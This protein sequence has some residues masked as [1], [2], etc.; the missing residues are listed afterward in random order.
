MKIEFSFLNHNNFLFIIIMLRMLVWRIQ[1]TRCRW[2]LLLVGERLVCDERLGRG[3]VCQKG[4]NASGWCWRLYSFD[5]NINIILLLVNCY[6]IETNFFFWLCGLGYVGSQRQCWL[7]SAFVALFCLY[8]R[9][10]NRK[11]LCWGNTFRL[12]CFVFLLTGLF[13]A[14]WLKCQ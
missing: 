4:Q 14:L 9:R 11:A 3:S 1:G 8:C 7:W 12:I 10:S 6:L 5:G 13:L 2:N